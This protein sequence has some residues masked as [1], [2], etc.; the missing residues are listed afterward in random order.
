ISDLHIKRPGEL[1][2]GKVDTAAALRR[3][4]TELNRLEPRSQLVMMSGDLA[5]TPNAE[6]YEHL[7]RL[8][9]PLEIPF[10][11]VPGNHDNRELMRAALP[12]A[13]AKQSGALNALHA[14]GPLDVVLLDSSV[15]G[16]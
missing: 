5:D 14:V 4:V 16:K 15:S 2:Y 1:A 7:K 6:E 8:L 12:G 11:A 9:A 3:C 10:V 13:Y